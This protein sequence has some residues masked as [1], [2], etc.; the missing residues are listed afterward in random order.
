M[1][2]G[3][4]RVDG[5]L[6]FM[7]SSDPDEASIVRVAVTHLDTRFPSLSTSQIESVVRPRVHDRLEHSR[8]KNFVGIL[9]E[10]DARTELER[11]AS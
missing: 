10:R 9:A 8:V 5:Y 6:L 2:I 7:K 4:S 3:S 11:A 1:F